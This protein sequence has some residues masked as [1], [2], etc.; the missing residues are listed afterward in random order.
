MAGL[1]FGKL[2]VLEYSH[3]NA[4]INIWKCLC[5]CGT[6]S[7]AATGTL[8]APKGRKSCGCSVKIYRNGRFR[9]RVSFV[10]RAFHSYVKD[11]KKRS[12]SFE[13]T[14]DEWYAL[15]QSPCHYCG[16]KDSNKMHDK[17]RPNSEIFTYNGIDRVD[18]SLG[19]TTSNC[20]P[21][22]RDCNMAKKTSHVEDFLLW[23]DRVYKHQHNLNS[24][25]YIGI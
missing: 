24:V 1:K 13:L 18:S 4:G 14:K 22:C 15:S 2:T 9:K 8:H 10:N 23:V 3:Q 16:I 12:K 21:C 5:D 25:A 6:I 11:A 7:Y 19:Y 17:K 20:V